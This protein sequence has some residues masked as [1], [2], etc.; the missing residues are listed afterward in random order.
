MTVSNEQLRE[1]GRRWVEAWNRRD[2]SAILEH[3]ADDVE[4]CSPLAKERYGAADGTVR[5]KERLREYFSAGLRI[6]NL[7]FDLIDVLIGVSAMTVVYRRENGALVTDCSEVN[8]RGQIIRM[9]ACYGEPP[10]RKEPDKG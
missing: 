4:I 10:V 1:A 5:G 9:I 2:L 8:D 7:H 3:Y 6:P